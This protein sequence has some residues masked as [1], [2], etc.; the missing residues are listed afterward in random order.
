MR[1]TLSLLLILL[2]INLLFR[3][4]NAPVAGISDKRIE[5]YGFK[6][7]RVVVDYQTTIENTDILISGGRIQSIGQNLTFPKGTVVSDLTGKT[8]YPSFIDI[9]AGNYGIKTS[10]STAD[11]NPYAAMMVQQQGGR[12]TSVATPDARPADY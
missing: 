10:T 8:V 7:A 3:Q 1:K 5:V 4:D 6:N 12:Q 2:P 11:V 9:Y